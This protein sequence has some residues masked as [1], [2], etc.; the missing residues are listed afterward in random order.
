MQ[1]VLSTWY[2]ETELEASD[3]WLRSLIDAAS[4][5]GFFTQIVVWLM[6][7]QPY[8]MVDECGLLYSNIV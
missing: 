4:K 1:Q 8:N 6:Q 7:G 2:N 5:P 3:Q